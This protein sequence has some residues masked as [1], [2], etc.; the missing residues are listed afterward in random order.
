M[1]TQ[2][3]IPVA[4]NTNN[5]PLMS[6][7]QAVGFLKHP[8]GEQLRVDVGTLSKLGRECSL[9]ARLKNRPTGSIEVTGQRWTSEKTYTH[10]VIR[11]VFELN[12][13]TRDYVPKAV[14][15]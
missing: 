7:A 1:N 4:P 12:P 8:S 9:Y 11:A 2:F 5:E 10:D 14:Q 13:A 15:S 3:Q 6:V